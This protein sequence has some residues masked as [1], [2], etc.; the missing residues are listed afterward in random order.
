VPCTTTVKVPKTVTEMVPTAACKPVPC[1]NPCPGGCGPANPCG[2]SCCPCTPCCACGGGLLK[3]RCRSRPL[4][5][6]FGRLCGERLA[7][8][9][10]RTP[11]PPAPCDPCP[12]PGK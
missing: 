7:C 9:P 1:P 8:D 10:C 5:D 11:C 4:R 12:A 6:L 3:D 2:P